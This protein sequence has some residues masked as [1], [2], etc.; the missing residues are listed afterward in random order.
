M[1][2]K[3]LLVSCA[4]ALFLSLGS[5]QGNATTIVPPDVLFTITS[6]TE[7]TITFEVPQ[8]PIPNADYAGLYFEINNIPVYA[9][10]VLAGLDD[11]AFYSSSAFGGLSD[12]TYFPGFGIE[13]AQ[14]YTG[15]AWD[16]TF[17]LG[18]YQGTYNDPM[19]ATITISATPLPSAWTMLIAG[20]VGLGFFSYRGSKN[21]VAA[22]TAL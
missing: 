22:T 13:T 10:G 21:N 17:V 5:G 19:S 9:N 1:S 8:N 11:F 14:L 3:T 16:P 18:T 4:A 12:P 6:Q 7:P 15:T 2:P 20:L